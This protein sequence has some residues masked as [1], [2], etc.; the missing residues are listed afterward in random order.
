MVIGHSVPTQHFLQEDFTMYF[1][2]VNPVSRSGQGMKIWNRTKEKLQE[3]HIPYQVSFTKYN[4]HGKKLARQISLQAAGQNLVV[5]GGDGT[6][7]EVLNG[8]PL[9]GSITLSYIPV[10]SGNDFARGMQLPTDPD[11]ALEK[12]LFSK[13]V[14]T[15]DVGKLK[16]Q[17]R[18]S[19]FSISSGIG[20]D[21]EVCY[22][23]SHSPMKKWLNRL[24]LGKLIYAYAAVK[25]L[26][27]FQ[28]SDMDV[29]LD[30][31]RHYH[32]TKVY[33]IAGMNLQ[34]E[35]GGFRFC[36]HASYRDGALDYL[37]VHD[38][39]K[40]K[41]LLLFP[42]AYFALHTHIPGITILQGKSI[43]ITS[44]RPHKLHQD[45]E[46]AGIADTV[47][48]SALEHCLRFH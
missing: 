48:M 19:Y 38:L 34:Y 18:T 5:I 7:N 32:F 23:V 44:T 29:V 41:I 26:F 21:A 42:T 30:G 9:D 40:W 14:Q 1:F 28:P 36:P 33:F 16:T 47:T 3:K 43:H 25:L 45:G 24:H 31:N 27:T 20:Y 6:I 13:D 46:F 15:I 37:I 39:S 8:L 2:I 35:G 4:G 10:G 11:L 17:N 22:E 12:I